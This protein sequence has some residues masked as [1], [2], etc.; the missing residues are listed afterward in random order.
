MLSGGNPLVAQNILRTIASSNVAIHS[1]EAD[2]V[3]TLSKMGHC[4]KI[5][6]KHYQSVAKNGLAVE[7]LL[8]IN[9]AAQK[10]KQ[11]RKRLTEAVVSLDD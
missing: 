5:A 3:A 8:T 4:H 9:A 2:K 10:S 11:S 7:G 6:K 1:D